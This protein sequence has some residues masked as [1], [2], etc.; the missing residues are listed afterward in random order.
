MNS[1]DKLVLRFGAYSDTG[2]PKCGLFAGFWRTKYV[3][4]P[5]A[6]IAHKEVL[7]VQCSCGYFWFTQTKD[8]AVDVQ[9]VSNTSAS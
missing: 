9:A 5:A 3:S 2:C 7:E 1:F 6:F 4:Y 8:K